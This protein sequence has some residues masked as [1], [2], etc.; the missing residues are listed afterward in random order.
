MVTLASIISSPSLEESIWFAALIV[1][2][3]CFHV[4][5]HHSHRRFFRFM[6]GQERYRFGVLPFRLVTDLSSP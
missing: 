1:K 6:I 5:V 4:A 3:A 2:D